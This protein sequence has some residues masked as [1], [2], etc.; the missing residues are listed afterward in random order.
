MIFEALNGAAERGELILVDG[1]MCHYHLRRDGQ[2]TIREILVL[3]GRRRQG[4]G[5]AMLEEIVNR[6]PDATSVFAKV[7]VDLEANK[8]YARVGFL[9]EGEEFS[10]SGRRLWLWRLIL[11]EGDV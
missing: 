11:D 4:I 3:P 10:R 2:I 9:C 1:G 7:P 8:W 5:R 6:C